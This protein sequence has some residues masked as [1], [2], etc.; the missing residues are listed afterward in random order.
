MHD[1]LY[2]SCVARTMTVMCFFV[3]LEQSAH[4]C[5]VDAL[6]LAQ[7]E[8]PTFAELEPYE[9]VVTPGH[10]AAVIRV[11]RICNRTVSLIAQRRHSLSVVAKP[12]SCVTSKEMHGNWKVKNLIVNIVRDGDS[13]TAQ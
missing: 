5:S 3:S 4:S 12:C 6:A 13:R 9:R 7:D 11:L 2:W 10:R 1:R 8:R